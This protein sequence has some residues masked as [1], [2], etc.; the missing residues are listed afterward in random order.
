MKRLLAVLLAGLLFFAMSGMDTQVIPEYDHHEDF[1]R[2]AEVFKESDPAMAA[3]YEKWSTVDIPDPYPEEWYASN[4]KMKDFVTL[5]M[6]YEKFH[7]S[8]LEEL[9]LDSPDIKSGYNQKIEIH[10]HDDGLVTYCVSALVS[11]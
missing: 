5:E 6:L 3:Y 10:L 1:K 2:L 11:G 4:G 7:G 8:V 9:Y